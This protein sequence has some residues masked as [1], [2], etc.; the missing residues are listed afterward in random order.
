MFSG[1]DEKWLKSLGQRIDD[2]ERRM[3]EGMS[4]AE[5]DLAHILK[6]QTFLK[7]QGLTNFWNASPGVDFRQ[8]ITDLV[9]GAHNQRK[10]Y[11]TFILAG[12]PDKLSVY[13]SYGQPTMCRTLLEGIF[14]GI[15]LEPTPVSN[16]KHTLRLHFLTKGLLTGI[17]SYNGIQAASINQKEHPSAGEQQSRS[18][19]GKSQDSSHLETAVAWNAWR[20]LGLHCPGISASA[21]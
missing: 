6:G 21:Y 5:F 16:L 12:A 20:Y 15:Q 7:I 17:P 1:F 9:T 13:V 8:H 19:V 14:P 10:A 4:P 2:L 18:N 3:L 11:L